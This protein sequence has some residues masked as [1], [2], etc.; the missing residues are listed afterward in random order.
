MRSEED[1]YVKSEARASFQLLRSQELT[2]SFQSFVITAESRRYIL[3]VKL[4]SY[5]S[6]ISIATK[7]LRM[8]DL[9]YSTHS[10]NENGHL[11]PN[12]TAKNS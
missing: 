8:K 1:A 7:S 2:I 5:L 4:S 9:A 6:N 11:I 10:I 12:S 3:T